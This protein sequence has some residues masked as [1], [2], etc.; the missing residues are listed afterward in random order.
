M[1]QLA[2]QESRGYTHFFKFTAADLNNAAFLTSNE[3]VIAQIPPGGVVTNAALY[4]TVPFTGTATDL[5]ISVGSVAGT[6]TNMIATTDIDASAGAFI[7][8]FNTGSVLVNTAATGYVANAAYTSTPISIRV[9]G[10]ITT[11]TVATGEWT[12]GL[13]ILDPQPFGIN[14]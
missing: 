5:S 10:T 4:E 2:N 7:L 8:G 3:K 9:L 11:T 6:S 14:A 13:T 1:P 12:V